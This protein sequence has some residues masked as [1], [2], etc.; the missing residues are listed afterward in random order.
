[1]QGYCR[2]HAQIDSVIG[3]DRSPAWSDWP[4]MPYIN[5]IIKE[6]HRWRPVSPLGVTHAVAE[7]RLNLIIFFSANEF[8][9]GWKRLSNRRSLANIFPQMTTSMANS[10][11][12][13]RAL[14]SMSGACIMTVTAGN[15]Q[16]ISSLNGSPISQRWPQAMQR[17]TVAIILAT[18]RAGAS[19]RASTWRNEI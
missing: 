7:G 16:S 18:G 15:H 14:F 4:Q 1:M 12:G 19:V 9:N 6:S 5:M 2:A 10:F 8:N 11:L 3:N 17:P 13:V